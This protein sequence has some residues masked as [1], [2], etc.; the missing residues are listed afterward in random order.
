MFP[1]LVVAIFSL[2]HVRGQQELDQP[3]LNIRLQCPDDWH[4]IDNKCYRQ[5]RNFVGSFVM[6]ET[7]CRLHSGGRLAMPK[8]VAAQ[9]VLTSNYFN[10]RSSHLSRLRRA[11]W[12]GVKVTICYALAVQLYLTKPINQPAKPHDQMFKWLD[13]DNV[14]ST[15]WAS[16]EPR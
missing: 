14:T 9:A 11:L 5:L 1:L 6:A 8:S 10:P 3:S 7:A 2:C 15:F 12:L 4:R 13:G 16:E